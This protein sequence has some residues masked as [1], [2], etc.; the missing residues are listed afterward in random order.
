[1]DEEMYKKLEKLAESDI[2][3]EEFERYLDQAYVEEKVSVRE[4]KMLNKQFFPR[5]IPRNTGN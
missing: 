4:A 5:C 1:M 3:Q 2:N